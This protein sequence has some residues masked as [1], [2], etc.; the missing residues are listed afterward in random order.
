MLPE[1]KIGQPVD[2]FRVTDAQPE[3]PALRTVKAGAGNSN[4]MIKIFYKMLDQ[5]GGP[6]GA[7]INI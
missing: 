3:D 6:A 4:A 5:G 1:T 7:V 2:Q